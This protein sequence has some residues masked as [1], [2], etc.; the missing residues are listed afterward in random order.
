[1]PVYHTLSR[2]RSNYRY[3]MPVLTL[4]NKVVTEELFQRFLENTFEASAVPLFWIQALAIYTT[5]IAKHPPNTSTMGHT[6]S[7]NWMESAET[8]PATCRGLIRPI[9]CPTIPQDP[10]MRWLSIDAQDKRAIRAFVY[11]LQAWSPQLAGQQGLRVS[12][13]N[14]SY[15][16]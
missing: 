9:C 13:L 7:S 10:S 14:N 8:A 6:L 12:R 16:A 5:T 15:I 2:G 4:R 1:M 11:A 3:K